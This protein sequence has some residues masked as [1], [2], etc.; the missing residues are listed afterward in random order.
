MEKINII[1]LGIYCQ[2]NE[3]EDEV[4][5][6]SQLRLKL[7]LDR[8]NISSDISTLDDRKRVQKAVYLAQ[9]SGVDLGY[10]YG[11]Y[12]MGPYSPELTQDYFILQNDI[13][14]GDS[15]YKEYTLIEEL[16]MKLDSIKEL[17]LPPPDVPLSQ[18]DWLELLA[19]T[20]YLLNTKDEPESREYLEHKKPHLVR[21]FDEALYAL[22]RYHLIPS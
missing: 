12:L 5:K 19:S 22:R 8:L 18:A 20:D 17:T 9:K 1:I 3:M 4:M 16:N 10:Q 13:L 14:K 6:G 15:M 7:L 11:W 2:D 21:Y